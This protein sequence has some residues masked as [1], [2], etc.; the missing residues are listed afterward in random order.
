MIRA[1]RAFGLGPALILAVSV[2]TVL[3]NTTNEAAY[4]EPF[5]DAA[6]TNGFSIAGTN[7]W[8]GADGAG[9]ITTN[10]GV[11]GALAAYTNAGYSYPIDTNHTAVLEVAAQLTNLISATGGVVYTDFLL[12][13]TH[14]SS[15]PGSDTNSQLGL[16][17]NTSSNLVVWH[18]DSV[19]TTNEWYALTD[20][21]AVA[22]GEWARVTLDQDY[23]NNRYQVRVNQGSP[24]VGGKG[25]DSASGGSQ[26]GSWFNMVQ[27]NGAMSEIVFQEAAYVD[28][29][30]V[31]YSDPVPTTTTT[32]VAP[33]TTTTV[34]PTTTTTT[35]APTTTTTTVAPTTT[36]TTVAPTTT[37]TTVA[38]STTTT[39]LPPH[40]TLFRFW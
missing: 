15:A 4:Q 22:T 25:W 33:T 1:I 27:T 9:V 40:G 12:M 3:A 6:Y 34:A 7:G 14:R 31:L 28:D 5:E 38:T 26:P 21:P 17:V 10:S 19:G 39:T 36:T 13:P 16:Y 18:Y 23:D 29:L 2:S 35:V 8:Y 30:Q 11:V 32:T 20:S 24:I 37:T